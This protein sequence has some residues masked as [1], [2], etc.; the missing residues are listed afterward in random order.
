[1]GVKKV[2]QTHTLGTCWVTPAS[3]ESGLGNENVL[4]WIMKP[5]LPQ[6]QGPYL[7]VTSQMVSLMWESIC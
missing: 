5:S 1:M 7:T 2:K 4:P 6:A 3:V